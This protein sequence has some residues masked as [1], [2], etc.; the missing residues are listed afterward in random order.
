MGRP[1]LALTEH[2][3]RAMLLLED[4]GENLSIC[5]LQGRWRGDRLR[6]WP[7]AFAQHL[8]DYTGV[9]SSI[10]RSSPRMFLSIPL[11]A[12]FG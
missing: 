10:K 2:Q 11:R 12:S 4:P 3:G 6:A 8:P 9:V 1:A 5:S 7:S